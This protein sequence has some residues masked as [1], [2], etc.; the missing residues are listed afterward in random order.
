MTANLFDYF[1]GIPTG[2]GGSAPWAARAPRR[3]HK[4]FDLKLV[5][6]LPNWQEDQD[7]LAALAQI[8]SEPWGGKVIRS[9]DGVMVRL[10]DAWVETTGAALEAG[11]SAEATLADLAQGERFSV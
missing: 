6:R 3:P 2:D 10:S 7:S 5:P 8:A 11:G 4:R 9:R 1:E